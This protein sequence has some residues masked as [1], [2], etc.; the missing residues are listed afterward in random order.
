M[1]NADQLIAI[2]ELVHALLEEVESLAEAQDHSAALAEAGE[3]EP[4]FYQMIEAYEKYLIRRALAKARGRKAGAARLLG[5]KPTT[6]HY[7]MKVYG[8]GGGAEPDGCG[9]GVA[10]GGRVETRAGGAVG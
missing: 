7:K 4:S 10:A 9:A 3:G 1:R 8:I 6:L 5:L 2:K